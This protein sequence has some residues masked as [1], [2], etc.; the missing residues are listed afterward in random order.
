M[1]ISGLD[2]I[3]ST[4]R[5]AVYGRDMREAI[6]RGFELIPENQ[7]LIDK[8]LKLSDYAADSKT[9]GDKFIAIEKQIAVIDA[10]LT[11]E[12]KDAF[13]AYFAKQ[14]EIHPE[15]EETYQ[16]IYDM[17]RP[18]VESVTFDRTSLNLAIG[19]SIT[20]R[21]IIKPDNAYDKTGV[22]TVEP[23]GI[24]QCVNG[25]VFAMAAGDA[26]VTFT[27]NSKQKT[28]T[29]AVNVTEKKYHSVTRNLTFVNIDNLDDSVIDGEPYTATL[30][31]I[32]DYHFSNVTIT[33]GGSNVTSAVFTEDTGV[34]YIPKVTGDVV[35]TAVAADIIY[36]KVIYDLDGCSA[37]P[38]LNEV[39]ENTT[40]E[41]TLTP[42][43]PGHMFSDYHVQMGGID[44]T[45]DVATSED[46]SSVSVRILSVTGDVTVTATAGL[47]P[48]LASSS[49]STI[50]DISQ[51]GKASEYYAVGDTKT[52]VINGM[53]GI[54]N[55][56]SVSID[57]FILGC[58]HNASREGNNRIHFAIGKNDD[59]MEALCDSDYGYESSFGTGFC[60]NNSYTN[61][62]GWDASF[63]RKTIL[64]NSG[65][66]SAPP[67]GS[68][69]AALPTDLRSVIQPVT[70]YTDNVGNGNNSDNITS[71]VDY[72]WLLSE[73]E[74][75][76]AHFSA[77]QY[78][79][80]YQTQYDYFKSGNSRVAYNTR[81]NLQASTSRAVRWWQRSPCFGYTDRFCMTDANG[82]AEDSSSG[83]SYA[84]LPAF[85]V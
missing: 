32:E 28:A 38:K 1:A 26:T 52:I 67:D 48:D 74:V 65:S 33:M 81:R 35:I 73:F 24:V 60:M 70:K 12:E 16:V 42:T 3:I 75:H 30:T 37:E 57:T 82:S 51:S 50:H 36:Y 45:D 10:G 83:T 6:A 40:L 8:T 62:D 47:P 71:T 34:I 22:W 44:I 49:W 61:R 58:N 80:N 53:V 54:L 7:V 19:M 4:I 21:P 63:M 17:W 43:V 46:G 27:T 39:E 85:A 64:G 56:N 78:E 18:P 14:V 68:L 29:C 25:T 77:N 20:L 66:N 15:L 11:T 79:Q 59:K 69:M 13:L 76:G 31:P 23:E 84:I 41:F 72:M 55:L 2:T 5:N 9:V